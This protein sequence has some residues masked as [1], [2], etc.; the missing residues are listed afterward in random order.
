MLRR[1]F[2]KQYR[3]S[4]GFGEN[5][6]SYSGFG[7]KG[8]NGLD[9]A[10][11]KGTTLVSPIDGKITEVGLDVNGYGAYVKIENDVEGH[12]LAHMSRIDVTVNQE[13]YEGQELGLSGGQKGDWGAGNTTGAHLH[14]GRFPKPRN[15]DNGYAGYEDQAS[16][17]I[18]W[19]EQLKLPT[20]RTY[21]NKAQGTGAS[22]T[23]PVDA[24]EFPKLVNKASKWDATVRD[25]LNSSR[26]SEEVD[27]Q[28][29]KDLQQKTRTERD[30]ALRRLGNIKEEVVD[31]K[32]VSYYITE[33]DN[34]EQQVARLK[35]EHHDLQ[36]SYDRFKVEVSK[37]N[38]VAEAQRKADT[39][40]IYQLQGQAEE[41][42]KAIGDLTHERD[43]ALNEKEKLVIRVTELEAELEEAKKQSTSSLTIYDALE[44]ILSKIVEA[45]KGIK[46]K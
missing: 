24:K 10:T 26:P 25:V 35:I 22:A 4:Q 13:V 42:G 15:R 14:W 6:A 43:K 30:E 20:G 39:L 8:H 31:G 12:L 9:Y 32:P 38:D 29:V 37:G 21:V 11:P 2:Y 34:R 40:L 41:Q 7:L 46:L 28:E 45:L 17:L 27:A 1:P 16:L 18:S 3:L 33:L 19:D 44:L 5:P 36:V 23:I